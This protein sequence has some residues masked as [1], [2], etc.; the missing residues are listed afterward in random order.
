MI[1]ITWKDGLPDAIWP[2]EPLDFPEMNGNVFD[3][4]DNP[5]GHVQVHWHVN[6]EGEEDVLSVRG[7]IGSVEF[8]DTVKPSGLINES[9]VN[10]IARIVMKVA[11][12]NSIEMG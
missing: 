3:A 5:I 1:K 9:V 7:R 11:Q 2:D 4:K 12:N 8:S 6:V 10:L